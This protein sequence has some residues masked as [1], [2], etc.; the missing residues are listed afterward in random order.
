MP[1]GSLSTKATL[2]ALRH[3]RRVQ[4]AW[5]GAWS[6]RSRGPSAAAVGRGQAGGHRSRGHR[7]CGPAAAPPGAAF[8]RASANFARDGRG[9]GGA[10]R[11]RAARL[12]GTPLGP[13]PPRREAARGL[14]A[15]PKFPRPLHNRRRGGAGRGPGRR[16]AGGG[17]RR[18]PR[19]AAAR[20]G[21]ARPGAGEGGA[22]PGG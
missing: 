8:L 20:R 19:P 13:A 4:R 12:C 21:P 16:G 14:S 6:S 7:G 3:D 11:A 2:F 1:D 10:D 9:G 15:D 22:P 18:G 17:G 5:A